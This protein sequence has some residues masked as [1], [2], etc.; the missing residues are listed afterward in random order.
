[1]VTKKKYTWDTRTDDFSQPGL[2]SKPS[3][4]YF[5]ML[6]ALRLSPSYGLAYAVRSGQITKEEKKKLPK[7]FDQVLATYDLIG[8]VDF[9]IFRYWW[10]KRGIAIFGN[11]YNKPEIGVIDIF[12]Q[13]QEINF[14]EVNKKV[15]RNLQ[16]ER[17]FE[18]SPPTLL[19]TIPLNLKK[20]EIIK[21]IKVILNET[22][23]EIPEQPADPLIK[24]M[25]KRLN[26]R[27]IEKGLNLFLHRCAHPERELWRLGAKAKISATYSPRLN[28]LAPRKPK[29]ALEMN[30]RIILSKITHRTLKR[31]E[32]IIENAARGRFP[33]DEQVECAVFDYP[34]IVEKEL[35][36]IKWERELKDRW[37]Q[38]KG[39]S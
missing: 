30:D 39:L 9:I 24:L 28:Y 15:K 18:G 26:R 17:D 13:N 38:E 20:T 5:L 1:M 22:T 16:Q 11:P 31:F 35:A 8:N 2:H 7:D 32:L 19:L 25:N 37:K 10:L 4:G 34:D 23:K 3:A 12:S 6:R 14:T 36:C 21:K 29:D 27:A 33:C